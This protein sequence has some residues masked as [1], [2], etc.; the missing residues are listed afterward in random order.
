MR[1]RLHGLLA[2]IGLAASQPAAAAERVL[3]E[4]ALRRIDK[5]FLFIDDFQVQDAF[6]EAAEA[7]EAAVPWLIA[8]VADDG[9]I[10]LKHGEHGEFGRI[11]PIQADSVALVD[12][13]VDLEVQVTAAGQLLDADQQPYG[14]PANVDLP[15]ELLRGV[16]RGLD[17]HSVVL[18]GD[19][20]ERFDE[21]ISGKLQ[22]IGARIARNGDVLVIEQVFLDGPAERGGVVA[23]DRVVRIDGVSTVGMSVTDTVDRIRGPE[24][25]QVQ[26]ELQRKREGTW[27]TVVLVLTR[28]EVRIP[29]VRWEVEPEGTGYI[30]ITHFSEQT[31]RLLRQALADFQ[32]AGVPAI[33]LDLRENSGGSMI[34]SCQAADLFL[35]AGPVLRTAGRNGEPVARLIQKYDSDSAESEPQIPVVVLVG[36]G[37]ASASEILAGALMLRDR[38][39]L[40]GERTHGKGTVQKLY[41][42]RREEARPRARFKLTVAR[43]LLPGDIPIE[44][45]VGLRS[46]LEVDALGFDQWA[47][48]IPSADEDAGPRLVWSDERPGWRD[49]GIAEVRGDYARE[50]ARDVALRAESAHRVDL[51]AA[52]DALV[53]EREGPED[54]LTVE[55]FRYRG[56]D[57]RPAPRPG[58]APE[59]RVA[60]EV[61]DDPV[62]GDLVEVRALV[63]N[64]GATALHRVEADVTADDPRL[65][66]HGLTLPVGHLPAGETGMGRAVVRID[67]DESARRDG[68]RLVVHADQRPPSEAVDSVMEIF[69]RPPPPIRAHARI[70]QGGVPEDLILEAT[71]ENLGARTLEDLRLKVG[72]DKDGPV[73]LAIRHVDGSTLAPGEQ[74]TFLFPLRSPEGQLVGPVSLQLRLSAARWGRVSTIPMELEIDG[75]KLTRR[76]P[77]ILGEVPLELPTGH[78]LVR[79]GVEDEVSLTDVTVWFD[80]NKVAWT[81][82][83]QSALTLDV[84]VHM[85]PGSHRMVVRA[86]DV[87]GVSK[88]RIWWIRG[89]PAAGDVVGEG[90]GKP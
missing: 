46:D 25:S 16:A 30:E 51:L 47:V 74:Q 17:R 62:A 84:P 56:I 71:F 88:R 70:R 67:D 66:W 54:Q 12:A 14:I 18:S 11:A 29:N 89:L 80:D 39:V 82:P 20:L 13:L 48:H 22:G 57:W 34:Q 79:V 75:P 24:G 4:D 23:G 9:S 28:D 50:L 8:E 5:H 26:L 55:T 45:G 65:P 27:E 76:P 81:S 77:E 40:I 31:T 32:V 19:R 3:Y 58:P 6:G 35:D 41:T 7:A 60:L 43:Y 61:V 73:E 83:G 86:T 78:H 69:P 64:R 37:S 10:A 42:L 36:P 87:H 44:T 21:R 38:T 72:L 68:V 63:E 1:P 52:V 90:E 2:L 49:P 33:L 53:A 85:E 59:V 15:V